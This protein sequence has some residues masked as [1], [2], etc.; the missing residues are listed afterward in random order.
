MSMQPMSDAPPDLRPLPLPTPE[1][2]RYHE[3]DGVGVITLDRPERF[4]ALT[5]A[6][7]R[8]LTD[9]FQTIDRRR[10]ARCLVLRGEG[11]AFC[12][13][14]DVEDIIKYLF[15][16]DMEGLLRFTRMTGELI[17]A[18]R[19]CKTPIVASVK[20]VAAGAGAVMA[21]ASDMRVMGEHAFF[22]FLFPQVGLSGADMGAS[23]LLPRVVGLGLAS[24][25]LLT[26]DR[27]PAA[28]CL[29][30]GLANRVVEDDPD[31]QNVDSEAFALA[32]KV[33]DGPSFGARMTKTM[34]QRELEM[35]LTE[36]IE[37]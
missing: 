5:F 27:V 24:E 10:E 32:K 31:R 20:R 37:A 26:G 25:I 15:G 29:Q 30:I 16:R 19:Q 1:H 23:Y 6:V 3:Q 8:E 12:S 35:G 2:F 28:R 22:A 14:G 21:L 11:R 18:M 7:Y 34:L 9:L 4:N 13:G 33:A 17:Y 36:A